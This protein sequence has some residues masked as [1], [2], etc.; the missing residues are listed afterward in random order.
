[1]KIKWINIP[2][3][4][5]INVKVKMSVTQ[6]CPTLCH[7]I[8]CSLPG[9]SVPG[10]L[11]A[12]ILECVAMPSP[13]DLHNPGIEPRSLALQADSSPSEPGGKPRFI[14]ILVIYYH[15]SSES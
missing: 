4:A 11:P 2:E 10:I 12:R 6:T 13:G 15:T 7:P 5:S 3:P 9:S 1:M 14:I 8:Y